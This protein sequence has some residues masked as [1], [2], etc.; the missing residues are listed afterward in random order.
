MRDL[1]DGIIEE[2]DDNI[3]DNE[4]IVDPNQKI[5]KRASMWFDSDLFEDVDGDEDDLN[6][7][8]PNTNKRKLEESENDTPNPKKRKKIIPKHLQMSQIIPKHLQM[9]LIISLFKKFQKTIQRKKN[10]VLMITI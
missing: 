6:S 5:S 4:L 2:Y 10:L 1:E 3:V 9:S 7:K 8:T